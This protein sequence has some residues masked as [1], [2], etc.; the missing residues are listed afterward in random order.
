MRDGELFFR[1]IRE[2][3][4]FFKNRCGGLPL[5]QRN[6]HDLSPRFFDLFSSHYLIPLPV[7]SFDKDIREKGRYDILRGLF[8]KGDE[9]VN[10]FD[11]LQYLESLN[12][13]KYRPGI[14]FDPFDG[15]IVVDSDD[16]NIAQL[17]GLF[18]YVHM[19]AV[20][21]IETTVRKNDFPALSLEGFSYL[22]EFGKRINFFNQCIR[23]L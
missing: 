6:E 17:F 22:D 18:E 20:D 13:G 14:P 2:A 23:G 5:I 9:I 11:S 1:S 16:E 4:N 19:T 3:R 12:Q 15:S 8:R 21:K 7:L 10:I